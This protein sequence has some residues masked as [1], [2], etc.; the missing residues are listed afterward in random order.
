MFGENFTV[1]IPNAHFSI[2]GGFYAGYGAATLNVKRIN[3]STGS[4]TE[5]SVSYSGQGFA[6]DAFTG[7]EYHFNRT[8]SIGFTAGYKLANIDELKAAAVSTNTSV[9]NVQKGDS[10]VDLNSRII[11]LNFSGLDAGISI[12]L[13]F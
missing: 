8:F 2:T 11:P 6:A 1:T 5:G 10:F 12:K 9:L 7:F 4:N 3:T 13:S